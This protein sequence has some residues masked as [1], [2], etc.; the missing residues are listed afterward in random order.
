[1][2]TSVDT[3][4]YIGIDL[5]GTVVKAVAADRQ[6]RVLAKRS[7]HT[8]GRD[9]RDAL[10]AR[11]VDL[12]AGLRGDLPASHPAIALGLAVPA[13]VDRAAGVVEF[14]VVLTPDW[15]GFPASAALERATGLPTTLANDAQAATLGE[16]AAGAARSYRDAVCI[17][18]GTG[19][20]GGLILDGRHYPGSRGM[21]G[22]LGHTTVDPAGPPCGCGNRG[23]LETLAS[24]HAIARAGVEAGLRSPD[25]GVLDA[26]AVA[27]LAAAGSEPA[28]ELF[29]RAGAL[30]GIAAAN[31]VLTLNPRAVVV[32]GGVARAGD[33]LLEPI[34]GEIVRR[35][36]VLSAE[37]GGVDVIQSPLAGWA[38]AIGSAVWA[39]KG[40]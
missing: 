31:V 29:R 21:S 11:L 24:G 3:S 30:I 9:G 1:M 26:R 7:V 15:N 39:A 6:G 14:Q 27:G 33:L 37:R 19:I 32:G 4:A 2:G 35:T 18:V 40:S 22:V 8:H 36:S 10:L 38:G 17:T 16:L 34:R 20:G 23:C 13:V 12:V 28:R 5:G 25:G